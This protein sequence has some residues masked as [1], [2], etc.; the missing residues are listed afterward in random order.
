MTPQDAP[1]VHSPG[2]PWPEISSNLPGATVEGEQMTWMRKLR[3]LV[4][5]LALVLVLGA[6][7][8]DD[9]GGSTGFSDSTREAYLEGCLEDGNEAFCN[10]T[11]D[12]FEKIYSED[13]FEDLALQLGS[14]D[15]APEEFVDVILTCLDQLDG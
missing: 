6:C 1:Q 13:E 7:G 5:L 11:L 14:P 10:C 9:D 4:P 8:D 3:V 12:E 2:A 15:E